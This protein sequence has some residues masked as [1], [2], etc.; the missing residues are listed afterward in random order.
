VCALKIGRGRA[1]GRERKKAGEGD[2]EREVDRK[3]EEGVGRE[4]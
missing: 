1:S 4:S 2:T 3:T